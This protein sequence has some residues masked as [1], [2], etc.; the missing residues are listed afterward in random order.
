M[1]STSKLKNLKFLCINT[2][3][4]FPP[5]SDPINFWQLKIDVVTAGLEKRP[6]KS[7]FLLGN[8]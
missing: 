8:G 2:V 4:Y 7:I 5:S 6:D 3:P 1:T